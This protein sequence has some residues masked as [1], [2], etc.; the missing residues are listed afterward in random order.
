MKYSYSV[1]DMNCGHCKMRIE[2]ALKEW[3]K[4]SAF[5]VDLAAKR[6]DIESEASS[7]DIVAMIAEAGYTAIKA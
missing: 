6:V 3:G 1:S 5:N 2:T 7:A 4:A